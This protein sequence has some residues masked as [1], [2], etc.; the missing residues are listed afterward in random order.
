MPVWVRGKK[1][2]INI[3]DKWF[4]LRFSLIFYDSERGR[5]WKSLKAFSNPHPIFPERTHEYSKSEL[6][7]RIKRRRAAY[8][9]ARKQRKEGKKNKRFLIFGL[10]WD[11]WSLHLNGQHTEASTILNIKRGYLGKQRTDRRIIYVRHLVFYV[12]APNGN[13]PIE[14]SAQIRFI[15]FCCSTLFLRS[16]VP[17]FSSRTFWLFL[18]FRSFFAAEKQGGE[19][20]CNEKWRTCTAFVRRV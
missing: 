14:S 10:I 20:K 18:A 12:R 15:Y 11:K 9:W 6:P 2:S 17:S 7:K 16:P 4:S 3:N 19:E 1:R 8:S 5:A 13:F